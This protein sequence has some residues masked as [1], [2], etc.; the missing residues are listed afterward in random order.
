MKQRYCLSSEQKYAICKFL[1]N[2]SAHY[3]KTNPSYALVAKEAT[4]VLGFS[5]TPAQIN[6]VATK[7][8]LKWKLKRKAKPAVVATHSATVLAKA[9]VGL[10]QALD[11]KL[12]NDVY[13]LIREDP[14]T[15]SWKDFS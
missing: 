13:K 14:S 1:S 8:E 4:T 3:R 2:N 11:Y 9:L 15:E 12:P 5:C 7:S 10:A 6:T